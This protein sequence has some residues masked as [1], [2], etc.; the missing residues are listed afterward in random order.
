MRRR[1]VPLV[2]AARRVREPAHVERALV[3]E[4]VR[5]ALRVRLV[6]KVVLPEAVD[7]IGRH[8]LVLGPVKV[9]RRLIGQV[10]PAAG[11]KAQA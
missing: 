7:L 10:H 6:R 4:E 11:Q 9:A 1:Q 8:R 2:L 3:T 5:R